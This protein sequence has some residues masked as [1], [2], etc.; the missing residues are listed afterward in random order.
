MK[1]N[2]II[3]AQVSPSTGPVTQTQTQVPANNPANNPA[4]AKQDPMGALGTLA[5]PF[6]VI[7]G[8]YI[9]FTRPQVKKEKQLKESIKNLSKGDRV[10]NRGGLWGTV[11]GI[12]EHIVVLKIADNVKVEVSK[13]AIEAINPTSKDQESSNSK[14]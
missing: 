10:V 11:V 13:S 6:V 9:L 7:V 8:L 4:A 2:E 12:Q 14:K 1:T 3:I 5:I